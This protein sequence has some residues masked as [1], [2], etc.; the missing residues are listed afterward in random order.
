MKTVRLGA[1]MAFWGDSVLPAADMIQNADIDYLCCDHLAELTMSILAKQKSQD[2]SF[3]YTRDI[4]DLLRGALPVAVEKGVKVITNAG[5][6]NPQA[7]AEA[8]VELIGAGPHRAQ[9]RRRRRRRHRTRIDELM[10]PG[11][12]SPTW[13]PASR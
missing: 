13:T 11:S 3:G 12:T 10:R 8:V 2:P 5:G 9:G 6:A 1:G 4:I 7:C